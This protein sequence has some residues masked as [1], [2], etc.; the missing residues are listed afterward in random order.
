M[1]RRRPCWDPA[2]ANRSCKTIAQW[3]FAALTYINIANCILAIFLRRR[4]L[5]VFARRRACIFL[6]RLD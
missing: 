4:V 2:F 1:L 3:R 6:D 5:T